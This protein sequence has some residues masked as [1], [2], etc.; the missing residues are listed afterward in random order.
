MF[1]SISWRPLKC[2]GRGRYKGQLVA[3]KEEEKERGEKDRA[4]RDAREVTL[5]LEEGRR[6]ADEKFARELKEDPGL[7]AGPK[8]MW[9]RRGMSPVGELAR[10]VGRPHPA[11]TKIEPSLGMF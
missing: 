6:L 8:H 7:L 11:V 5:R 9:L 3:L 4:R 2:I 10:M 1:C